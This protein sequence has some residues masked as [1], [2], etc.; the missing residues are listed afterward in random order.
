[1]RTEL[2]RRNQTSVDHEQ[3]RKLEPNPPLCRPDLGTWRC[4]HDHIDFLEFPDRHFARYFR[5]DLN[6]GDI[7]ILVL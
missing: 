1:M 7:F 6:S 4:G 3:H 5:G 2:H